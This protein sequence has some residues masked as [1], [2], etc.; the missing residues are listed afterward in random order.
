MVVIM[1]VLMTYFDSTSGMARLR[2]RTRTR[3]R[4]SESFMLTV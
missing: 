3:Q 2:T 4:P 1:M